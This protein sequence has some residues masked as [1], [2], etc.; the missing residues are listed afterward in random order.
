MTFLVDA[1]VLSE[2]T[3][4][5]PSSKVI[6]WLSANEGK[7]VVD[8]IVLGELCIGILALPRGRKRTQLEQWFTALVQTIECLPWD[9]TISQRWAELVVDLKRRGETLP[10][11]DGMIAATALQHDLTIA[12]RNTHDFKK[13]DAKVLDPFA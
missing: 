11:L 10:L 13:T 2:P 3:K 5:A 4:P 8:S 12:T 9:A 1:N 7:L 6:E